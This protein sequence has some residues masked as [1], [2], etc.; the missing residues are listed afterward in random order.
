MADA[1]TPPTPGNEEL[2]VV[3]K[4][5]MSGTGAHGPEGD[6]PA[7]REVEGK[8][9]EKCEPGT[10]KEDQKVADVRRKIQV[11]HKKMFIKKVQVNC[12]WMTRRARDI[13]R[14]VCQNYDELRWEEMCRINEYLRDS[15][16]PLKPVKRA[17]DNLDHGGTFHLDPIC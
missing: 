5:A 12:D 14:L 17:L 3:E 4:D 16:C 7:E 8:E 15:I 9:E 10:E 2:K 11:S 1:G 6:T 13:Q